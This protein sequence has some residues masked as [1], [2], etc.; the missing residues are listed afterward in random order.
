MKNRLHGGN[1]HW[2]APTIKHYSSFEIGD[3]TVFTVPLDLDKK[4]PDFHKHFPL[5][6]VASMTQIERQ[7]ITEALTC[8]GWLEETLTCWSWWWTNMSSFSEPTQICLQTF[9]TSRYSIVAKAVHS[10][11]RLFLCYFENIGIMYQL[12]W[13]W[14]QVQADITGAAIDGQDRHHLLS[15]LPTGMGKTLPMLPT[16]PHLKVQRAL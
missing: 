1:A 5:Y 14:C 10:V 9:E 15:C 3:V 6:N 4:W 2:S 8:I 12:N 13:I 16:E 11:R 7:S